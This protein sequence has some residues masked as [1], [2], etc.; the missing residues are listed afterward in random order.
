MGIWVSRGRTFRLL[1][2]ALAASMLLI[3]LASATTGTGA[4]LKPDAVNLARLFD[5]DEAPAMLGA[6]AIYR[7]PENLNEEG[8]LERAFLLQLYEQG[9][10]G[11]AP[12]AARANQPLPPSNI[13]RDAKATCDLNGDGVDDVIATDLR[14]SNPAFTS[15]AETFVRAT[16]GADGKTLWISDGLYWTTLSIASFFTGVSYDRKGEPLPRTSPSMGAV[17]DA[18][19]DGVCDFAVVDFAAGRAI[20]VPFVAYTRPIYTTM[21][22][23]SGVDGSDIWKQVIEGDITQVNDP[24]GYVTDL[25][26]RNFPTG[27]TA[28]V[29]QSGPKVLLKTTDVSFFFVYDRLGWTRSPILPYR[30]YYMDIRT[31]DHVMLHDG[32]NGAKLWQRDLGWE[33]SANTTNITWITGVGDIAGDGEPEIVLDSLT[34]TNPRSSEA[35]NPMTGAPVYRYA[36]GMSVHALKGEVEAKG[37]SLWATVIIDPRLPRANPPVEENFEQLVWTHA[38]I[39]DDATADGK[40]DVVAQYLAVE[41]NFGTTVNGAFRTHFVP[42]AGQNG[43]KLWDVRF[44]GWG[45]MST[46]TGPNATVP[47]MGFGTIDLPTPVPP[48]SRFP[49]KF[50]RVG[51]VDVRDGSTA[52]SFEKRFAQN[53]YL[54]AQLA[55]KQY[56]ST[57]APFDWD[58][59]GVKEIITPSQYSAPT[60]TNQVL[61]AL[62]NHSYEVRSGADGSVVSVLKAWGPDGRVVRCAGADEYVTIVSGHSR[63][64]D[65]TR[66]DPKTGEQVWRQPV[67]NDPAPRAATSNID[68]IGLGAGCSE[69]SAN[70]TLFSVNSQLYSFDRSTEVVALF[71]YLGEAGDLVWHKPGL[72]GN[73]ATS[74]I[75]EPHGKDHDDNH[76][77]VAWAPF[78]VAGIL[79]TLLGVATVVV[80]RRRGSRLFPVA[81]VLLLVALPVTPVSAALNLGATGDALAALADAPGP[82]AA[83]PAAGGA[84]SSRDVVDAATNGDATAPVFTN[85]GDALPRGPPTSKNGPEGGAYGRFVRGLQ[86]LGE[87]WTPEAHLSLVSAYMSESGLSQGPNKEDKFEEN[88]TLSYT[89]EVGDIDGDGGTDLVLDEY[90]IDRDACPTYRYGRIPDTLYQSYVRGNPSGPP[91]MLFGINGV[92][93]GHIWNRSLD[94]RVPSPG[95]G[96][97]FVMGTIPLANTTGIVVY[98]MVIRGII[99]AV[100]YH[101]VYV[102]DA[103]TGKDIWRFREQGQYVP[104]VLATPEVARN[105]L[106]NV[107]IQDPTAAK[108]EH[109]RAANLSAGLL[110]QGVGWTAAGMT[111]LLTPPGWSGAPVVFTYYLPDEWAAS[112]DIETGQTVW[113]RETFKPSTERNVYPIVLERDPVSPTYWGIP[114]A[115]TENYWRPHVCCYDLTGD[116]KPDLLYKVY[117]W[118]QYPNLNVNGPHLLDAR[119]VLLDGATGEVAFDRYVQKDIP[120]F[121][122][123]VETTPTGDLDGDGVG[124][125]VM[126]EHFFEWDYRH[127]YSGVS[128]KDGSPIWNLTSPRQLEVVVLGDA[129]GDGGNDFLLLDWYAVERRTTA[130]FGEDYYTPQKLPYTLYS[131]AD[132]TMIWRVFSFEAPTDAIHYLDV[133][134][135]NGLPDFDGDGVA[136]IIVDDPL[137][138]GD[139]TIIHRQH[140]VSGR[141]G[142]SMN[143]VENVGAFAVPA[144]VDDVTGDGKEDL[145]IVSGD[146]NDLWMTVYDAQTAQSLWSRRLLAIQS[147]SSAGAFPNLRF[148]GLASANATA[149]D[150]LVNFHFTVWSV[151][152]Y[153]YPSGDGVFEYYGITETTT[154]QILRLKGT[155][156][157][158]DWGFPSVDEGIEPPLVLGASPGTATFETLQ[159]ASTAGAGTRAWESLTAAWPVIAVF[160]LAFVVVVGVSAGA[161]R[162]KRRKQI[163][164]EEVP[165]LDI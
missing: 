8:A 104:A 28:Y 39:T 110:L 124:D 95:L 14:L 76:A 87:D 164:K 20:S 6:E 131:G 81:M 82:R 115:V 45:F 130:F 140:V 41:E 149:E 99:A 90:C 152:R 10:L 100:I 135:K 7:L 155:N 40:A 73:P 153:S 118:A 142:Q 21:R 58:G 70:R 136:D 114:G 125:F 123:G 37:E 146:M 23:V 66:F 57:L 113:R 11:A 159:A 54:T 17:N 5:D 79:G 85:L 44:Q 48:G 63:R 38:T 141:T 24:Y 3:P 32:M 50:V 120:H 91:H 160:A 84:P 106:I 132:G 121:A 19:G 67:F 49:P 147:S 43:T 56:L 94:V 96:Q 103:A 25:T 71:G 111:T 105:V 150:L 55:A 27:F 101:D 161:S 127:V 26:I 97:A 12:L 65:L 89:Y 42:L 61:L 4:V 13:F 34:I 9:E 36:R 107:M 151:S 35:R 128:G 109:G 62:S 98:Q 15:S 157:T 143:V 22:V 162:M 122:Y 112:L 133:L 1:A 126:H 29:T 154:P 145:V 134:R 47:L 116:G 88:V 156:G 137:F 16:S 64:L 30:F 69:D 33:R 93:G 80:L 53:S 148:H 102:V 51:A 52:W 46:L 72:R 59:D 2:L 60:G 77:L 158:L 68:F 75:F 18:N 119:L 163:E 117:E 86:A 138:L 92:T 78:I 165:D 74:S 83:A 129:N 108:F 31:S 144:R 139:Q